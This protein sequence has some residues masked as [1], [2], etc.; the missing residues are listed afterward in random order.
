MPPAARNI[1]APE[2]LDYIEKNHVFDLAIADASE[3]VLYQ[4]GD[5]MERLHGILCTPNTFEF[6]GLPALYGRVM[7]PADYEPSA[8]PTFVL[9]YK[10]WKSHFGGDPS[11][12]GRNFHSQRHRAHAHRHHAAAF[13]M[14]QRRRFSSRQADARR[15]S[16]RRRRISAGLV[17]DG[18]S[19]ARRQRRAG[20]SRHYRHRESA[21]EDLSEELSAA[22]RGENRFGHRHGR[23]QFPHHAHADAWRSRA[24]LC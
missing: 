22:L 15:T 6:F 17:F 19:E 23:R 18:P 5:G 1:P 13:W 20:A 10:A 24:A 7:E 9:G 4:V 2:F 8:P 3:D 11:I 21:R 12:I 14:G 16:L